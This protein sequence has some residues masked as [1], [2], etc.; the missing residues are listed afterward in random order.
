MRLARSTSALDGSAAASVR[1]TISA[2]FIRLS[3]IGPICEIVAIER[4]LF[5][6]SFRLR[7][8]APIEDQAIDLQRLAGLELLHERQISGRGDLDEH[9]PLGGDF[10]L[11]G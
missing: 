9:A 6:G 4:L 1:R 10:Q 11:A 2:A 8:R 3:A 7:L 5:G